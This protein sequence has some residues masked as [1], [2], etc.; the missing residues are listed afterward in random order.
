MSRVS[1]QRLSVTR[2]PQPRCFIPYVYT[3]FQIEPE[4]LYAWLRNPRQIGAIWPSGSGLTHAM[5]A[6]I[7]RPQGMVVELGAGTGAITS[8]LLR[9]GL[10]EQQLLVVEKD[11]LLAAKLARRFPGL[12]VVQGDATRLSALLGE[13]GIGPVDQ[14]VSSLPLLSLRRQ[15]RIRIL[16]QVMRSLTPQGRLIQFTYSPRPPI[17]TRLAESLQVH[18]TRMQRVLWNLPPAHVWVYTRMALT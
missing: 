15:T 6:Q 10:S 7:Q 2:P 4:F 1:A 13:R 5:A 14:V 8:A 18:G 17:A 16:S 9:Q 11:P 12:K 3:P